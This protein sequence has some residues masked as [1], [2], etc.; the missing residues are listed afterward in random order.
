MKT[1]RQLVY[2]VTECKNKNFVNKLISQKKLIYKPKSQKYNS[3]VGQK[4]DKVSY[5]NC[6]YIERPKLLL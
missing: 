3:V 6:T 5:S 2:M 4:E 1:K